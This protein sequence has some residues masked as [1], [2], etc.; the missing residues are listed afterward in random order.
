[1]NWNQ[2]E[3]GVTVSFPAFQLKQTRSVTQTGATI[4]EIGRKQGRLGKYTECYLLLDDGSSVARRV[5]DLS[6]PATDLSSSRE[7]G[8]T[9]SPTNN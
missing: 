3:I 5:S 9:D 7:A 8:L 4:I 1:M 2:A 6:F